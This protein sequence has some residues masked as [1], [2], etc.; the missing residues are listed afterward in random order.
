MH[1]SKY[2]CL[3][4]GVTLKT[5]PDPDPPYCSIPH[6]CTPSY[7][8]YQDAPSFWNVATSI[9]PWAA[10]G[11]A[12]PPLFI[13]VSI[14]RSNS[15]PPAEAGPVCLTSARMHLLCLQEQISVVLK[16]SAMP[17]ATFLHTHCQQWVTTTSLIQDRQLRLAGLYRM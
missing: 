7:Q 1:C 4:H 6:K 9:L 2:K 8:C 15:L 13:D 12:L 3:R 14:G 16:H 11:Q 17:T 5:I 10:Q